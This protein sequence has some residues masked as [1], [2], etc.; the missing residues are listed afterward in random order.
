M[1]SEA[2]MDR[3][4]EAMKGVKFAIVAT[5]LSKTQEQKLRETFGQE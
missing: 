3:V 4:A 5:N 1:T 2:V